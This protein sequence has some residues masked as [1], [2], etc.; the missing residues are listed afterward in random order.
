MYLYDKGLV[1][2]FLHVDIQFPHHHLLRDSSLPILYSWH[3]SQRS[4]DSKCMNVFLVSQFCS[5]GLYVCF[6]ANTILFLFL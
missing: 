1:S 6:S 2:L 5:V 4:I 3:P